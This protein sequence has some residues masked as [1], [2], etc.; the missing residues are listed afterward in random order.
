VEESFTATALTVVRAA[1]GTGEMSQKS[2]LTK[3]SQ[4]SMSA[5][6]S[7]TPALQ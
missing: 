6:N 3:K 1:G 5:K 2:M 4:K 7:Q